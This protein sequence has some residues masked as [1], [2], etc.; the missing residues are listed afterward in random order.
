MVVLFAYRDVKPDNIMLRFECT[1]KRLGC[2]PTV[3][4]GD[5]GL[6]DWMASDQDP[7]VHGFVGSSGFTAP[8]MSFAGLPCPY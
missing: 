4:L 5:F 3:K 2:V 8:G 6:S 7:L 1:G